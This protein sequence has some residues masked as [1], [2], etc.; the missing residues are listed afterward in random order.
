MLNLLTH[1]AINLLIKQLLKRS[2]LHELAVLYV[3]SPSE[4]HI[5]MTKYSTQLTFFHFTLDI[6]QHST[7]IQSMFSSAF[8]A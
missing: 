1:T 5:K 7:I 3:N 6:K 4:L 8:Y 2:Q